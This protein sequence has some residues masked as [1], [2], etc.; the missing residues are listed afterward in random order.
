MTT[1]RPQAYAQFN[2]LVDL[3]IPGGPHAGFQELSQI[4][5]ITGLNKSTDVTMKR[6][7]IG[8]SALQDWLNQIK[9]APKQA[10]RTVGVAQQDEQHQIIHRWILSGARIIKHTSA[11]LNAKGTD[12]AIEELVLS[13][14]RI[15]VKKPDGGS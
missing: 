2:F 14:E 7:V 15:E 8:S 9:K 10:Q 13:C 1:T 6:G 3:G 5:K 12:V 11:P 4:N